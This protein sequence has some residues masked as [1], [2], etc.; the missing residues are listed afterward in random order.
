MGRAG[1]ALKT[2]EKEI[3]L[4]HTIEWWASEAHWKTSSR[5]AR[6]LSAW[7]W[8]YI[9]FVLYQWLSADNVIMIQ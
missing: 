4:A 2:N 8:F 5:D 3:G 9:C 1:H 7:K 6:Y